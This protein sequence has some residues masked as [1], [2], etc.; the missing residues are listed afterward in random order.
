GVGAF[1]LVMT[2]TG[3]WPAGVS[4][5]INFGV[6][7]GPPV[8]CLSQNEPGLIS[9]EDA[10]SIASADHSSGLKI[11]SNSAARVTA[12]LGTYKSDPSAPVERVWRVTYT[13]AVCKIFPPVEAGVYRC[14]GT[15]RVD[16]NQG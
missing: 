12:A 8:E 11:H 4:R 3:Q 5:T 9:C 10:L 7:L 14:T 16:A 6:T 15:V 2:G 13:D 1:R